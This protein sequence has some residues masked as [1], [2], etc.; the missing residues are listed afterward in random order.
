MA[1]DHAIGAMDN[2]DFA[3]ALRP[4]DIVQIIRLHIVGQDKLGQ[5]STPIEGQEVSDWSEEDDEEFERILAEIT[6]EEQRR[7]LEAR[8]PEDPTEE[9]ADGEDSAEVKNDLD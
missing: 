6:A 7:D 5:P 9:S 8:L 2:L 3:R 4:Q 1:Y